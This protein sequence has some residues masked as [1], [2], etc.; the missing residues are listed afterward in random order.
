MTRRKSYVLPCALFAVLAISGSAV[1]QGSGGTP[2]LASTTVLKD[3][4]NVIWDMAFLPD[5]AM[6]FTERC[7][8]LSVRLASGSV[9]P[10]LGIKDSKGYPQT[11]SDLFCSGQAGMAGHLWIGQGAEIGAQAS[12]QIWLQVLKCLGALLSKKKTSSDRLPRSKR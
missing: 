3:R 4:G 10:L 2:I 7:G 11:A 1:A 6:F 8:G 5:G 12:F 9:V